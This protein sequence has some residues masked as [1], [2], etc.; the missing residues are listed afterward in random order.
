MVSLFSCP[1][2]LFDIRVDPGIDHV[3]HYIG[4]Y[5][6]LIVEMGD[7]LFDVETDFALSKFNLSK[8]LEDED[9]R[10]H[11]PYSLYLDDTEDFSLTSKQTN[12]RLDRPA[13]T[14]EIKR[15]DGTEY[16]AD[17]LRLLC[18]ALWRHLRDTCRQY[19]LNPFN[20]ENPKFATFHHTLDGKMKDFERVN[21]HVQK[22][23]EP[24]T[25]E[26]ENKLWIALFCNYDNDSKCLS[27]AVYF[28]NCKLFALRAADEHSDLEANQYT[29]GN[30]EEG[31]Y[32]QFLGKTSKNCQG[33][34]Y[35]EK[36]EKMSPAV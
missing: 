36:A 13:T 17:S 26:E 33:G 2:E 31:F 5:P 11:L 35:H 12:E 28:Y 10:G 8:F 15:Q 6:I 14:D 16:P 19:D 34:I 9:K 1:L 7:S 3:T 21:P 23:A 18:T 20:K 22:R 29:F 25:A 24:I 4:I 27:Y 30:S 32:L